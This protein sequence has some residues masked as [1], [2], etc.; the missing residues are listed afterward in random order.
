[1]KLGKNIKNVSWPIKN[2]LKYFSKKCSESVRSAPKTF[3]YQL[4]LYIYIGNK[5]CLALKLSG[6]HT[7]NLKEY[8]GND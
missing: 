2:V 8:F 4:L 1:M 5:Q 3:Y 6:N 7:E